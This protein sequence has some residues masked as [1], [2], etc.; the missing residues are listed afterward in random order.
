MA[1]CPV[2]LAGVVLTRCHGSDELR[3]APVHGREEC[4]K[5][6]HVVAVY[7]LVDAAPS[8]QEQKQNT[9][10]A[11]GT[12]QVTALASAVCRTIP[13]P[14]RAVFRVFVVL[15]NAYPTCTPRWIGLFQRRTRASGCIAQGS[16]SFV[17]GDSQPSSTPRPLQFHNRLPY[18]KRD[19]GSSHNS[20]ALRYKPSIRRVEQ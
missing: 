18:S 13:V 7:R 10:T 12:T 9:A 14:L 20:G 3:L 5:D 4:R 6:R 19:P 16:P 17:L 1:A 11:K 15:A 2:A 8:R